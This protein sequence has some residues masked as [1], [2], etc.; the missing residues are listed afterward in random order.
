MSPVIEIMVNQGEIPKEII[1]LLLGLPFISAIIGI[2]RYYIGIKTFN[3]YS[4]VLLTVSYYFIA[5]N[6]P[7]NSTTQLLTGIVWGVLFTIIAMITTA[8][9]NSIFGKIRMHYYPKMSFTF[10][11][12][13]IIYFLIFIILSYFNVEAVKHIN[14]FGLILISL[15]FEKFMKTLARKKTKVAIQLSVET[16]LLSL[17][18]YLLLVLPPFQNLLLN[19]PGIVIIAILFNYII[20]RYKGLRLRELF[21]FQDILNKE[22]K[23]DES[24]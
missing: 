22:E 23:P 9:V 19:H 20:G 12:I 11:I 7:T 14:L 4:S 15:V 8:L 17:V 16:I 5:I 1:I 2:A 10:G 24:N 13:L 21:R 3:L 18:C 6:Y